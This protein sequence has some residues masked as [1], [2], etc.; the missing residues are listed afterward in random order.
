MFTSLAEWQGREGDAG[1]ACRHRRHST[2]HRIMTWRQ[3]ASER[4]TAYAFV[5]SRPN[6]LLECHF[7]RWEKLTSW[8]LNARERNG[9]GKEEL[10]RQFKRRRRIGGGLEEGAYRTERRISGGNTIGAAA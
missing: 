4:A 3:R 7:S 5:L 1:T 10:L 9:G 6:P 2:R 8:D